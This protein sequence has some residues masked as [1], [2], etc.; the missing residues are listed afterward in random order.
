MVLAVCRFFLLVCAWALTTMAAAVSAPVTVDLTAI[1]GVG[2]SVDTQN[3]FGEGL[4]STL[5]GQVISGSVS[6][7]P[8]NLA[9]L[10]ASGPACY[11]DFGAGAVSIS[12]TLNGITSAV[13]SKAIPGSFINHAVGTVS[14][15]DPLDG[16][17][18]YL[19]ASATSADGMLQQSIGALF[20][21]ATLF[22]AY[23]SGDPAA[24]VA[25]LVSIGDGAGLVGGGITLLTPGE[26]LDA[27]IVSV[28]VAP[29]LDVP[30]SEITAST[31]VDVPEPASLVLLGVALA[32]LIVARRKHAG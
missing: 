23:G 32:G 26:H 14:I 31:G 9:Q 6:I 30:V 15:V 4:G 8:T 17:F 27:T 11:S 19:S 22:S 16:C 24:A 13:V 21:T 2:N 1:V 10:C 28:A 12:F 25:T 20:N 18:N 3:V 5:S 7:D 29:S